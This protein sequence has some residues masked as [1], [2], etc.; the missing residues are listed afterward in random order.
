[1]IS[2]FSWSLGFDYGDFIIYFSNTHDPL[3]S[4][5]KVHD[6]VISGLFF[7]DLVS[8][9]LILISIESAFILL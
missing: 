2:Y 1:M 3:I 6:P 7:C 8:L 5:T 4:L 9:I